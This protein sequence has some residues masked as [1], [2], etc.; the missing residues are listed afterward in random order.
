M[1][2][3]VF[4]PFNSD[5]YSRF[6]GTGN[7]VHNHEVHEVCSFIFLV[8]LFSLFLFLIFV[9][10]L[11][12]SVLIVQQATEY[13]LKSVVPGFASWLEQGSNWA[14]ESADQLTEILHRYS[15]PP[16]LP[17]S[18][19]PLPPPLLPSSPP[20]LLPSSPLRSLNACREGI[21]VR[22]LG[23]VRKNLQNGEIKQCILV[24]MV[25]RVVKNMIRQKLRNKMKVLRTLEEGC[26]IKV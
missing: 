2:G 6:G 11:Y 14:S 22:Y 5:A 26:Y 13:L 24:E 20:P 4:I 3:G 23:L 15:P 12:F 16:L 25:A 7:N 17:S 18:P 8:L 1:E 21:N 10:V 9:H 19:P